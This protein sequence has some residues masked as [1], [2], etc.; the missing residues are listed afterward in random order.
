MEKEE[1]HVKPPPQSIGVR[2]RKSASL[3]VLRATALFFGCIIYGIFGSPTPDGFG[4]AESLVGFFLV[5]AVGVFMPIG[6]FFQKDLPFWMRMGQVFLLFGLIVPLGVA[7]MAGQD[8]GSVLRDLIP[9]MFLFLPI[10]MY[11]TFKDSAQ[12]C[13]LVLSGFIFVGLLFSMR[14][15]FLRF[16]SGDALLYLENMPSVLFACLFLIGSAFRSA[17]KGASLLRSGGFYTAIV[18]AILPFLS[19]FYSLQRASVGAVFLFIFAMLV[20]TFV[21]APGRALN[22]VILVLIGGSVLFLTLGDAPILQDMFASL[23]TF[24]D[25]THKVGFNNRAQEFSAV[26]DVVTTNQATFLFGMGW[27][28]QF[29]SPAVGGLSVNFTHN[30]FSYFLLKTGLVGVVCA[31]AY[32]LGLCAVL[33]RVTLKNPA[34]GLALMAPILIDLTL[35]ASFKSLD[36]GLTLLMIPLALI[37]SKKSNI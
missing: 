30:F 24:E 14:S 36:F 15:L 21:R 22:I 20:Y 16:S 33:V 11:P 1:E 19:M 23:A 8:M 7:I 4:I 18:I 17:F 28:A 34:F 3:D 32:I 26:W 9:F 12:A 13:I 37:Y 25:K 6:Q 2:P 10:F 29:D 35:Y 27:G 31:S 5:I